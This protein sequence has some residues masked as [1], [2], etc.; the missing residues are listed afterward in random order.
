[1][2]IS[3]N[4]PWLFE[5]GSQAHMLIMLHDEAK[6][7]KCSQAHTKKEGGWLY[8]NELLPAVGDAEV[9]KVH[10]ARAATT[11]VADDDWLRSR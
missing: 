5:N 2:S 11:R 10:V 6:R 1:M 9:L 7:A 4:T 3:K 8:L